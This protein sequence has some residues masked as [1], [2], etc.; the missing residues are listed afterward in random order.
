MRRTITLSEYLDE[1][2]AQGFESNLYVLHVCPACK[3]EQSA[4]DL[5][6][7]GAGA[8][9]DEVEKYLGFS[10]VGRF[11]K[12][13]GC[14]W[15]LG[16]LFQIHELVVVDAAGVEYPR[17]ELADVKQGKS[18]KDQMELRQLNKETDQ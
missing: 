17:F 10:C 3:T 8:N 15:T 4:K 5:I 18:S 12:D 11:T 13:K 9:F 6:D 16:G 7:A 14:D 1:A 2:R